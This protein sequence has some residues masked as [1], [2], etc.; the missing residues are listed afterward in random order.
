MFFFAGIIGT[1]VCIKVADSYGRKTI[2]NWSFSSLFILLLASGMSY[3]FAFGFWPRVVFLF[4]IGFIIG[5]GPMPFVWIVLAD[6]MPAKA[7]GLGLIML[8]TIM[9]YSG[10]IF[11]VG[12]QTIGM[13]NI[14]YILSFL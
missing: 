3:N 14:F 12:I 4:M 13:S 10:Y 6:Y 1:A 7:M 5:F 9:L 11:P 2:L 8:Y